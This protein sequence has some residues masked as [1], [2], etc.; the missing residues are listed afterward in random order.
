MG[1]ITIT[2]KD[3]I[4]GY[5]AQ[6]FS[7]GSGI[8]TLPMVLRM[9]ST[10][11]IAMN[12]LMLTIGALVALFDFGFAP[13]FGRNISYIFGGAQG[14]KKEGVV[15]SEGREI[16]YRLLATM[17]N[18]ARFVYRILAAI[19][20]LIMLTLGTYYIYRITDGFSKVDNAL[21]IWIIYSLSVFFNIYFT[22]YTSL[23]VGQG[24]IQESKKAMLYSR[25]VYIL[26]TFLFLGLGWG[27]IGV[28]FSSFISPFIARYISYRYFFTA[29]MKRKLNSCIISKK[30]KKDLLK[31]VWYNSKKLGLVFV[32]AYAVNKLSIFLAG[33]YLPLNEIASY[34]LMIQ[35]MS[36][37]AVLS[38]TFSTVLEPKFAEYRVLNQTEKII[39]YFSFSMSVFYILFLLGIVCIV[40][41]VPL[42]LSFLGSNAVLPSMPIVILYAIVVLLENNHSRFST[43]IVT[44]NKVPFVESSLLAGTAICIGDFLLLKYTVWGIGGLV[45]VQGICQLVY[46]N[47]KWP[48]VVCREFNISYFSF[49]KLGLEQIITN[50]KV[51]YRNK[52]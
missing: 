46:S 27:L 45:I 50:V 39:K 1:N 13:Q 22:Y 47:W 19:S 33:L 5:I 15:H 36:I 14:L 21:A 18:V 3:V 49:L 8:I 44:D 2:R 20:L 10:E 37:V 43:L 24:A 6:F 30:E 51:I 29:E 16:N 34:G 4:W 7:I 40:V 48:Y 38:V 52:G 9:L 31:I 35:L 42:L 26:L 25:L 17:I 23:L 41:I 32:G 28:T 11:E 12:Y